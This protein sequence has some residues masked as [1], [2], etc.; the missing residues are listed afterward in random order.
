[1][2]FEASANYY[3]AYVSTVDILSRPGHELYGSWY[4]F[5]RLE[6]K[7]CIATYGQKLVAD[8]SDVILM[9][10][11]AVVGFDKNF[12]V[13]YESGD[14][15]FVH[16]PPYDWICRGEFDR[17]GERNSHLCDP[18]SIDPENWIVL[19]E[20]I[21]QSP[22]PYASNDTWRVDYCMSKRSSQQCKLVLNTY[23]LGL[24]IGC[25]L[26]KLFGLAVTW[27]CLKQRPILTLGGTFQ[28]Y[29]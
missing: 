18:S 24:V 8:Q 29:R 17:I 15:A 21:F 5:E 12:T 3:F 22:P 10:N 11:P 16:L 19:P 6:N 28:L 25:N 14:P 26:I 27:V 7:E 13:L 9:V 23:I 4:E 20:A 2:S 1:M